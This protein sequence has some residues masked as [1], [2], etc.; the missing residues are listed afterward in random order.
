MDPVRE[1]M[2]HTLYIFL[3][4]QRPGIWVIN[5]SLAKYQKSVVKM[6]EVIFSKFSDACSCLYNTPDKISH[7]SKP[8]IMD[9]GS[10]KLGAKFVLAAVVGEEKDLGTGTGS[11]KSVGVRAT[12]TDMD[13]WGS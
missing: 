9:D 7:K 6:L 2:G 11:R 8:F 4:H 12:P 13:F 10:Q 5:I 1:L 3:F